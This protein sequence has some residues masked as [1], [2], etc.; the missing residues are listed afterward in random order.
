MAGDF[1]K[2]KRVSLRAVSRLLPS[3]AVPYHGLFADPK[4]N[5]SN[6]ELTEAGKNEL[7]EAARP[8]ATAR[9]GILFVQGYTDQ[10]GPSEVNQI[11]S[12]QRAL[13]VRQ[14]LVSELK[15]DPNRVVAIGMGEQ[16]PVVADY[17]PGY[18]RANRRI[19]LKAGK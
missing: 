19:V 4:G 7:R 10:N 12:Y 14:F 6:F 9:V 13:T 11:E 8:F 5:P 15:F 1:V 17:V 3:A 18:R 16:E 2:E